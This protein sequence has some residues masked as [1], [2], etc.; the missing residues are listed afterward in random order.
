MHLDDVYSSNI[1]EL[2]DLLTIKKNYSTKYI[3]TMQR[4]LKVKMSKAEVYRI[5]FG[6]DY[7]QDNFHKRPLSKFKYD[8]L[9]KL[10]MLDDMF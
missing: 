8:I 4:L 6:V 2:R 5:L 1:S 7:E 10:G 3:S 9:K